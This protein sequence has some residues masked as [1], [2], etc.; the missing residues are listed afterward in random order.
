[1]ERYVW[2]YQGARSYCQAEV[3]KEEGQA[4]KKSSQWLRS[5]KFRYYFI[6]TDSDGAKNGI[7]YV[8]EIN[9]NINIF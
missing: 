5:E 8:N 6:Y 1:M 9:N 3:L 7:S 4:K 2:I